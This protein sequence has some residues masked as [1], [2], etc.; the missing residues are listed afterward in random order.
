MSEADVAESADALVSGT[1]EVNPRVGSS[2]TV[3][4]NFCFKQT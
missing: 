3:R 1:K 2:P 4:T